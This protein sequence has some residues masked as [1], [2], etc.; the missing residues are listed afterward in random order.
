MR[1]LVTGAAGFIGSNIC[2]YLEKEGH[3]VLGTD[4]LSH[5]SKQNLEG[6]SGEFV[7]KELSKISASD[8][9]GVDAVF[10]EAAISDPTFKDENAIM[11]TNLIQSKRIMEICVQKGV[12]FIYAS[13]A[14]VYG[15]TKLPN[16][17][18]EAEKPHNAYA[19]SKLLL[20]LEAIKM[21]GSQVCGL[22]Y[23]NVYGPGEQFKGSSASMVYHFMKDV[24]A[25][26]NP[27]IFG[28]G[29]QKR[30]FVYVK[31]VV[32]ANMLALKSGKS[33]IVNVGSGK[34]TNF[35]DLVGAISEKTGKKVKPIYKDNPFKEG[36][37][38]ATEAELSLAR[39]TILYSPRWSLESGLMDYL[40][41]LMA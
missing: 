8:I 5:G 24:L 37:Q 12:P 20:D 30:D 10:H 6:F 26:K 1:M 9:A 11:E 15:N 39:E 32:R 34:A 22:R 38:Y 2:L 13:S 27:V 35:T 28:D 17:E 16:K 33:A 31:D 7:S 21:R 14:A 18:F 3:N 40:S 19:R 23:F 36:Y 29:K 41:N 4:N 25:G